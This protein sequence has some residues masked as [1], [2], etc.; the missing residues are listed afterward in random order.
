M[1]Y[2]YMLQS[3][4]KPQETYTG[5][6]NDLRLRLKAHNEGKVSSTRRYK[7]WRLVYYEAYLSEEDARLREQKF[8]RHGIGNDELK[9]RIQGSLNE[10][11][12]KVRDK[13]GLPLTFLK[14]KG[15]GFTLVELLIVIAITLILAAAASPIYS[16]LQVSAQVNETSSQLIQTL[17]TA[18]QRS[19]ARFQNA[20][21]GVYFDINAAADDSYTL[22]KGT[23]YATRDSDWDRI[24]ILDSALSISETLSGSE[25]NFSKSLGVPNTTGNVILTHDVSGSKTISINSLGSI[26]EE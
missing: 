17:R 6:T 1:Y 8:K 16:N 24:L 25:V 5:S 3:I 10:Y 14:K 4:P 11:K 12:K 2:F 22:Y 7:P 21:W 20:S 13:K 26:E 19:Q 18:R 9:K 23:T 15:E